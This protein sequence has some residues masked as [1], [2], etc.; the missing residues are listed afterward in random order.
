M[1]WRSGSGKARK[2]GAARV[3]RATCLGEHPPHGRPHEGRQVTRTGRGRDEVRKP[4]TACRNRPSF[5][6]TRLVRTRRPRLWLASMAREDDAQTQARDGQGR[7]VQSGCR[8]A[9]R[10]TRVAAVKAAGARMGEREGRGSGRSMGRDYRR[11]WD[12]PDGGRRRMRRRGRG[13]APGALYVQACGAGP[14]RCP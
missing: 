10:V 6:D 14:T 8:L 5:S 12:V 13:D 3:S 9:T 11:N 7:A 4:E 2:G 1:S